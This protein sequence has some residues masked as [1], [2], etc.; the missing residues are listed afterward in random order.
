MRAVPPTPRIKLV[1]LDWA[2]TAVDHGSFAPVAAFVAAFRGRGVEVTAQQ[3]RAP[4]GLEKRDHLRALA[5]LP[6]D[7]RRVIALRYEQGQSFADIGQA[8]GRSSEAVRKLW[9]R[10]IERLRKE[11]NAAHEPG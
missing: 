7:Y 6:E 9:F 5:R 3:A 2:G 4:M 1:V 11:L 8:M 10:A